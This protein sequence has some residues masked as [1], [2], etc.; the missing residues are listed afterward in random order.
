MKK[1]K[2]IIA[3]FLVV[4]LVF[5]LA[6]GNS[7]NSEASAKAKKIILKTK[8]KTLCIGERFALKVKCVRPKNASQ[9][10]KFESKHPSVATVDSKGVVKAKKAGSALIVVRSWT[11]KWVV[12]SCKVDVLKGVKNKSI[13]LNRTSLNLKV[14]KSAK[15]KVKKWIP[16]KTAIKKVTW[17]SSNKKVAKVSKNG[18]IRAIS[19]GKAKITATNTYGKKAVCKVRV[20]EVAR[21]VPIPSTKPTTV[22]TNTPT[23]VPTV[24]PVVVEPSVNEE[25]TFATYVIPKTASQFTLSMKDSN[26]TMSSSELIDLKAYIASTPSEVCQKWENMEEYSKVSGGYLYTI[27][28]GKDSNEK[29][30]VIE[31]NSALGQITTQDY[32]G[33][34]SVSVT[35]NSHSSYT[36][37]RSKVKDAQGNILSGAGNETITFT[38]QDGKY[39]GLA[40]IGNKDYSVAYNAD[41]ITVSNSNGLAYT[42]SE[43]L[44]GYSIVLEKDGLTDYLDENNVN[45]SYLP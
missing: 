3:A 9:V 22:P 15:L 32:S 29:T 45:I 10:V 43:T 38:E 12:A 18:K 8:K 23:T 16:S 39:T 17:K 19:A 24:P 31:K 7:V 30:L 1:G 34:Y 11:N 4:A 2:Q 25:G 20:F 26:I 40:T 6:V 41:S 36:I 37:S 42:V 5:P 44:A 14:G 21:P 33:T 27:S 13:K 35:S 28:G